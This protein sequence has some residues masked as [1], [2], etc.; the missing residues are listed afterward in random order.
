MNKYIMAVYSNAVAGRDDDY[1][2]W[3]NDIHLGEVLQL[4]GFVAAQRF[5]V[6]GEPV[7]GKAPA[8]N[9]LAIYEMEA[10]DPQACL[11]TLSKAVASGKL[12]VSD[13]IEPVNI[14]V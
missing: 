6:T 2:K 11:D 10:N 8:H 14:S 12:N 1:N 13:A 9:Y 4:P 3:Y 5:A 7:S